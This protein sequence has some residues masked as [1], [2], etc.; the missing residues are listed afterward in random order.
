ML[1]IINTW[2]FNLVCYLI[3]VVTFYQSY[4]LA[5][6]DALN[7]GAAT[8][9][10]QFIAGLSILLL[11]P[12]YPLIFPSSYYLWGLL[13]SACI[14]YALNDRL[15]TTVR[16]HLE[17]SIFTVLSQLTSVFMIIYGLILFREPVVLMKIIG[18]A[19]ILGANIFLRFEKGR[20]HFSKY[21]GIAAF[22]ALSLATALIIDI[23]I[24][25]N[26]N[27]PIYISITFLL[28]A[29]FIWIVERFSFETIQ[30][31]YRKGNKTYYL[32][33]GVSW[34]GTI[35]FALRSFQSGAVS[36][37]VPLQSTSILLSVLVAYLFFNERTDG[38][39][40][41]LAAILV[42]IGVFLTVR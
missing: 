35:L 23:G 14:F 17:V 20:F 27:L 10:L 2:Q 37:I 22:A 29:I 28:P 1:N 5:V 25:E 13:F 30:K 19:C 34:A 21:V 15:Q 9:L 39:K 18:A 33:A 12:L 32:L 7:D 16:K 40:K 24:S 42:I 26:F 38:W 11:T 3:C 4:K 31:E 36:T 8:V 41:I 6:K